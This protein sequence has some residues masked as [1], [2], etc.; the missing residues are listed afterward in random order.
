Q[1]ERGS[2]NWLPEGGM[3]IAQSAL[4]A[5][6]GPAEKL[7]TAIGDSNALTVEAWVRQGR[8]LTYQNAI[9]RIVTLS[10]QPEQR[11]FTL[12]LT[13]RRKY[14]FT[15]RTGNTGNDGASGKFLEGGDAQEN[16]LVHLVYTRDSAGNATLYVNGQAVRS[17]RLEGNLKT[18]WE[19][20][21]RLALGNELLGAD[22]TWRGTYHLVAVY[23]RALS[24]DEVSQN[25]AARF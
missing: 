7:I 1:V 21:F 16:Q 17:D 2:V 5:S 15:L 20:T 22:R 9:G 8:V 11:N 19:N 12:G 25:F 18:V 24:P 14:A 13:E 3:A 6:T 23:G 10:R 4:V